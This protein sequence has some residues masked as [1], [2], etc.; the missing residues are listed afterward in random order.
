MAWFLSL[1]GAISS[2]DSQAA[3]SQ[4]SAAAWHPNILFIVTDDQRARGTMWAMPKTRDWFKRKGTRY[5]EAFATTPLC[6]PSRGSIFTG[7]FAHNHGLLRTTTDPSVFAQDS[8]IQAYLKGLGY[9][10]AIVGKYL[11]S[12]DVAVDPPYFDRWSYFSR[13]LD[14]GSNGYADVT[15]NVQ[16]Q[17]RSIGRYATHYIRDRSAHYLN[18]FEKRDSRPWFL[19][20]STFAPHTPALP[21]ASYIDETVPHWNPNPAIL[22]EDRTDK[23]PFIQA[24][25]PTLKRLERERRRQL[26]TLMSVDDMVDAIL[27]KAKSHRELGDTLAVFMSDNGVLWGEHGRHL[28]SLPYTNS[29][30]IPLFVRRP[31]QSTSAV[32]RRV[33]TNLDLAPTVLDAVGA[34]PDPAHP[35]DGRSLLD[36]SWNRDRL[37]TEFWKLKNYDVPTWA[38]LRTPTYQYVEYYD[39]QDEPRITFREYYDL[40]KD[41][42][43]LEN[44]LHQGEPPGVDLEALS[45]QLARDRECS[46]DS[47]P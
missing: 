12:W 22:E 38:S 37:V 8:T 2:R 27:G 9:R 17:V 19:Y 45:Q 7:R 35:M 1:S 26:R 4:P 24:K 20:V 34:S 11:N 14:D 30:R 16:G 40:V 5:P 29:L 15:F 18:W 13:G 31:G 23:P 43:Q 3:P 41:P 46:D 36:S 21:A 25:R 47:C 28:K 42:W 10:T 44:V 6:C 32:D 39:E 33:V